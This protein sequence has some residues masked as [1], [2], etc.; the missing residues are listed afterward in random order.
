MRNR[1]FFLKSITL[2]TRKESIYS[3]CQK[4]RGAKRKSDQ[5]ADLLRSVPHVM[6][7]DF[8][9]K[10]TSRQTDTAVQPATP[11]QPHCPEDVRFP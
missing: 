1:P 2:R 4:Y 9:Q 10:P 3:E 8:R 7:M 5:N 6:V 11:A